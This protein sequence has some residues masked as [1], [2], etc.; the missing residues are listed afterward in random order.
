M[1]TAGWITMISAFASLPVAYFS[2]KLGGRVDTTATIIQTTIQIVAVLIFL[3][4]TLYLKKLLNAHFKFHDTDKCIEWM[5]KA[6]VV[7]G[8]L[9]VI[10]LQSTEL[11]DTLGIAAL[12]IMV[13]QGVVQIQFGYKLLKL[14]HDLGGM[15]KPFCYANM[16][17]GICIASVVLILV[18]ILISAIADLMLGTI[19]FSMAKL[20]KDQQHAELANE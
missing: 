19:F 10:G 7:A 17:T 5:I 16:A 8:I 20:V 4:I 1:I 18:G 13:A 9:T 11:R 2:W 14:P 6:N 3:T 15:Q 12:L